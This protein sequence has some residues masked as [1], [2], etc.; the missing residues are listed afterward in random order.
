VVTLST[1]KQIGL[2]ARAAGD[3]LDLGTLWTGLKARNPKRGNV[4]VALGMVLLI[5]LLDI[6][7]AQA[8]TARHSRSRGRHRLYHDRSGFPRGVKAAIGS[9]R[10]DFEIPANMRAAPV[11]AHPMH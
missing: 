2:W 8:I 10:K 1:E 6:F 5:M 4:A 7:A 11:A 3:G 9:A